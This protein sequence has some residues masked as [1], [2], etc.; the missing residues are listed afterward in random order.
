M[1]SLANAPDV[2]LTDTNTLEEDIVQAT[3]E[4]GPDLCPLAPEGVN[5][6]TATGDQLPSMGFQSC[7]GESFDLN[8]LCGA[9]ATWI[10]FAHSWCGDCQAT[11]GFAETVHGYFQDANVA[12]VQIV[13]HS[14]D[15]NLPT[16]ADCES[17]K[18][19]YQLTNVVTLFDPIF[20]MV[21]LAETGQTGQSVFLDKNRV[22]KK[23]L[24]VFTEAEVI[25]EIQAILSEQETR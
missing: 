11:A 3:S 18:D 21:Q 20:L 2:T 17:W 22:I 6:G 16:S 5:S 10:F 1:T 25:G 4:W 8:E 9:D 13:V 23:K 19:L 24:H 7:D 14:F 12:V 15:K